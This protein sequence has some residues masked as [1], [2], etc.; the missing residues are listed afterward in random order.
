MPALMLLSLSGGKLW[1]ADD[2]LAQLGIVT[3]RDARNMLV[4]RNKTN[5]VLHM[6]VYD[7][8]GQK[9]TARGAAWPLNPLRGGIC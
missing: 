8:E 9:G 6:K 7:R 1:W 5:G 4:L 3:K 2:S